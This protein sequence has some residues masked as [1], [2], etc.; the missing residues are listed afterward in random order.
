MS[1]LLVSVR[2]GIEAR[3]AQGVAILDAKEI[4][5]SSFSAC[6]LEAWRDILAY[7]DEC[8]QLSAALGCHFN[9][10]DEQNLQK[11]IISLHQLPAY[12]YGKIAYD[13]N[14]KKRMSY[15]DTSFV[16]VALLCADLSPAPLDDEFISLA[17]DY[18][19]G[20]VMLDNFH[21]NEKTL[22]DER[23]LE[24]LLSFAA[25]AHGLGLFCAFAG[26][27]DAAQCLFLSH[28]TPADY[29]GVRG[30]VC[31]HG[32]EGEVCAHKVRELL[33]VMNKKIIDTE[34]AQASMA[35]GSSIEAGTK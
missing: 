10:R 16:R 28:H 23:K 25:Q 30:A 18:Q 6:S 1:G 15:H 5:P 32:R 7:K 2:N 21:K 29:I 34:G 22:L 17:Y 8:S 3:K 4:A 27:L 9:A 24:D 20:G 31:A 35:R 26:N 33:G 19:F 14:F 12:R 11:N 13:G